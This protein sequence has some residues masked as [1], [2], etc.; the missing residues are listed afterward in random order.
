[1]VV[2]TPSELIQHVSIA[3]FCM[4]RKQYHWMGILAQL[5]SPVTIGNDLE[6]DGDVPENVMIL[7]ESVPSLQSVCRK[8]IRKTLSH[9]TRADVQMLPLSVAL[10][11]YI[12]LADVYQMMG[13]TDETQ[14][15]QRTT[16]SQ[17]VT[18]R[19]QFL[20]CATLP[21]TVY[22]SVTLLAGCD[23]FCHLEYLFS[24]NI[25]ACSLHTR[26]I[27]NFNDTHR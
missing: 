27:P 11:N 26:I 12:L 20:A 13:E 5:G 2:G 7:L 4:R 8:V 9:D 3:A 10:K 16:V 17:A 6:L 14:T 23:S 21:C 25:Y 18:F 22:S 24:V 19:P 1:M 15:A